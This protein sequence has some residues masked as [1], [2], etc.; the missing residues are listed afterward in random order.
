MRVLRAVSHCV[1]LIAPWLITACANPATSG[2]LNGGRYYAVSAE[3]AAF[4]HYGPQQGNGPDQ[5][6]PRDTLLTIIQASF[7][8]CKVQLITGEKGYVAS[9]DIHPAS[10]E[11]VAAATA[12]SSI[13]ATSRISKFRL[14]PNDPRFMTPPEPLPLDLPEPTP[15]P[16][17]QSSPH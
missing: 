1:V 10:A 5:K 2:A 9:E 14:N 4:Y 12:P 15:I 7:G 6:L 13:T 8:Y 11:L 17:T 3:Q 16:E